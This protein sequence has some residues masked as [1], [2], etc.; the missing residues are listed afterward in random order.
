MTFGSRNSIL[1]RYATLEVTLKEDG[2]SK[3]VTGVGAV[4]LL[5]ASIAEDPR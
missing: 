3:E 5:S 4:S 2:H 1:C